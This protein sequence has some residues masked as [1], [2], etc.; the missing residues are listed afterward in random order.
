MHPAMRHGPRAPVCR[1]A[2]LRRQVQDRDLIV[3]DADAHKAQLDRRVQVLAQLALQRLVNQHAGRIVIA[4]ADDSERAQVAAPVVLR[5]GLVGQSQAAEPRSTRKAEPQA[6]RSRAGS[7]TR[8][9]V[10]RSTPRTGAPSGA[11]GP[12]VRVR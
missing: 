1:L 2:R 12:R 10:T 7:P 4:D 9:S 5:R 3:V 8:S 11:T 6:L